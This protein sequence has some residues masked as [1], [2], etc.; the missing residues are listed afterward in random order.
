MRRMVFVALVIA[1]AT[2]GYA[3]WPH[4]AHR[5]PVDGAGVVPVHFEQNVGQGP[6]ASLFVARGSETVSLGRDRVSVGGIDLVFGASR[7]V[8]SE[9]RLAGR[10]DYFVGTDRTAWHLDVP[11]FGSVLYE[12]VAPGVDLRFHA[13]T[14]AL[15]HDFVV[16]PGADV[17]GATFAVRGARVRRD[18]RDLVL[19]AT[20]GALRLHAPI[21]Y[22]DGP[23]GRVRVPASF[24]VDGSRIGFDVGRYDTTRTLVIDP[25][26]AYRTYLGG[27]AADTATALATDAQ[28]MIFATGRTGSA[29]FP[30]PTG[31][32][33]GNDAYVVKVDPTKTGPGSLVYA[34]YIGGAG[35]DSGYGIATDPKGAVYLTGKTTSND[36]PVTASGL[37]TT[38]GGTDSFLVKIDPSKPTP[39]QYGTYVGGTGDDEGRA[40]AVDAAGV[41]YLSGKTQSLL[42]F[43]LKNALDGTVGGQ[44]AFLVA[45]DA[46]QNG[47]ASL[48]YGSYVGGSGA[49]DGLGVAVDL[50]GMVS[51]GGET[52]S[53]DLPTK[54]AFDATLGG[55]SDAFVLQLDP[56]KAG[57]DSLRYGT[58][59]GGAGAD[60]GQDSS[61]G[62]L[63]ATLTGQVA[64][65][66][67]TA[68][69]DFPT[70][71]AT[72]STLGGAQDAFVA[73]LDP[74]KVGDA[75]LLWSTYVG[76]SAGETGDG[77]ATDQVGNVLA[78][79]GTPSTDLPL[80]P[81]RLEADE[82]SNDAYIVRITES[83]TGIPSLNYASYDGGS[84]GVMPFDRAL[85]IVADRFGRVS[86]TGE[87]F[88]TD[89]ADAA[90]GGNGFDPTCGS[91]GTCDGGAQ[92]D[93]WITT[94]AF[95][96]ELALA[97]SA[98]A[99][100]RP[101]KP[102]TVTFTAR[103]TGPDAAT[104]MSLTTPLPAGATAGTPTTTQGVCA[105]T[106]A[107]L[108]CRFGTLPNGGAITV[109]LPLTPAVA[110]TIAQKASV[111]A[112]EGDSNASDDFATATTNVIDDRTG[113]KVAILTK[114]GAISKGG[115]ILLRLRCPAAEQSGPCSG[116]VALR[117]VKR[118]GKRFVTLGS[119][120]FTVAPGKIARVRIKVPAKARLLVA[121]RGSLKTLV[122]VRARDAVGNRA[123]STR[124]IVVRPA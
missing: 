16:A 104:G 38:V 73:K 108:G 65:A 56:H 41:A 95:R 119:V 39:L 88:S 100:G 83:P 58:Y 49:E 50:A 34:A 77:V 124:R 5:S 1:G 103:N 43:P 122:S 66:G 70:R 79:G 93:G 85:A 110:G 107:T 57:A 78:T 117:S 67:D 24:T 27:S 30:T 68:S 53:S 4:A 11:A 105:V 91:D 84:A 8:V 47:A 87:T 72:D 10:V 40:I 75:S 115:R 20:N 62:R 101:G 44:D 82:G 22:Q 113:P 13:S 102:Y 55:T 61:G 21:A 116:T 98:P 71:Q 111:D 33:P 52:T 42:E 18:G 3:A 94:T 60:G 69:T 48:I 64:I 2:L 23:S 86:I 28:G 9:Q 31:D 114:K 121:T 45:I 96:A 109:T 46:T 92:S 63:A 97:A 99:T 90:H 59:L 17:T 118:I 81:D 54:N 36:F 32:T 112:A 51:V 37:D 29:D 12:R 14:G 89:L 80:T 25:V 15:E 120:R 7:R 106:G 123:R 74:S 35:D 6:A 19:D 76:G 26:L